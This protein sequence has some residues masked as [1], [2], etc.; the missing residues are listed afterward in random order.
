MYIALLIALSIT[1]IVLVFMVLHFFSRLRK[2]EEL[3]TR[4]REGQDSLLDKLRANAELE[5]ELMQSFACRQKELAK[6]DSMLEERAQVLQKL[7]DQAEKVSRSPQ[8][9]RELIYA[10][11]K[12]GKSSAHLAKV[13]GLSID[14]V[15]LIL[16][17]NKML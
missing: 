13:T 10:G 3:L 16:S 14:E 4:L 11:Y 8:F 6:L 12:N 5:R 15:E 17:Q 7:L 9:L 1:E 2:S